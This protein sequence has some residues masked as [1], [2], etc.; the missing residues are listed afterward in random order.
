MKTAVPGVKLNE[1]IF[2]DPLMI[3]KM[4]AHDRLGRV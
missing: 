3:N 4:L 2:P 1:F